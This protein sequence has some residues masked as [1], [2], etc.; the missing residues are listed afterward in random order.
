MRAILIVGDGMADRPIKELG[1]KTP[2]EAAEP[3][4]MDSVASN[5][6]SG[7]L[8]PIAPGI[9]PG[10]DAANLAILGYDPWKIRG[11][12]PFEAA[13]AGIELLP[14][15]VAFRCNF[16]TVNADFRMVDERAGRIRDEAKELA[17]AVR[18]I[19]L[20]ENS[21]VEVIF[22]HTLGFKG[23]LVLRGEGMSANVIAPLPNQGE[24]ADSVKPLNDLREARKTA[25]AA[26]EFIRISHELLESHRFN[27]R[28]T[29]ENQLPANVVIPWSA[30][31]TH[32]IQP[33]SEKYGLKAACVAGANLIKGIAK[34]SN[35]SIIDVP[36]ATGDVDTNTL[37]KANAT[38][39]A[40][41]KNDFVMVHVEGPDEASHAGDLQGK[42]SIIR[43]IDSMVG[44]IINGVDLAEDVVVLLADHATSLKLKKHI[45]DA[46]PISIANTEVAHD[47]VNRYNERAAYQGGLCRI[48]GEHVMPLILNLLGKPEKLGV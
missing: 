6:V 42:M 4:Q 48:R 43:K 20:R 38:L 47:N 15:D 34:L 33:F 21:D 24:R 10:S 23:A 22:E 35:M 31:K 7:L 27:K 46:V 3:K 44:S 17:E 39:K 13:G 45:G 2:L 12:G 36:E 28:R 16:A 41:E 18:R 32:A 19:R 1:Y 5:G 11:R 40:A 14:G 26:N 25:D 8:D 30:D 37:A 29:A 9:A